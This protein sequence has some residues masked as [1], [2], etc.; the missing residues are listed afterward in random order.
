M[1]S[2]QLGQPSGCRHARIERRDEEVEE[3]VITDTWRAQGES[4]RLCTEVSAPLAPA[5]ELFLLV[6]WRGRAVSP[7]AVERPNSVQFCGILDVASIISAG[8]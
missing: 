1:N 4:G 5:A 8:Y 7:C 3:T 2:K 6:P